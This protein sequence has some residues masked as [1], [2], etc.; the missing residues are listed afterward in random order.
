MYGRIKSVVFD[1][2]PGGPEAGQIYLGLLLFALVLVILRRGLSDL[3][4]IAVLLLLGLGLEVADVMFL[5]QSARGALPDLFH[6]L[7]APAFLF[8]LARARLLR[9]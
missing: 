2:L 8:G 4:A 7:L 3:A 5:G 1:L 6:F 9:P